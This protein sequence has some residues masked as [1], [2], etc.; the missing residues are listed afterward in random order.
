MFSE[1]FEF[2]I[3]FKTWKPPERLWVHPV[4]FTFHFS[5]QWHSRWLHYLTTTSSLTPNDIITQ[6]KGF[7]HIPLLKISQFLGHI[8][9]FSSVISIT[10][11]SGLSVPLKLIFLVI[12]DVIG[13]VCTRELS[14]RISNVDV[15]KL[16]ESFLI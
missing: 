4:L 3:S 1:L 13:S 8:F 14:L 11:Y 10:F 16:P 6:N 5:I 7:D 2:Q 15:S 9:Y 12:L